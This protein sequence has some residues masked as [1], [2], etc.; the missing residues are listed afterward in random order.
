MKGISKRRT[1]LTDQQLALLTL[2]NS[3][4][5]EGE[6]QTRLGDLIP[7]AV[8]WAKQEG[9][10][11]CLTPVNKAKW[12]W[13]KCFTEEEWKGVDRRCGEAL[14]TLTDLPRRHCEQVK[15]RTQQWFEEAQT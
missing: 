1:V 6:R 8:E 2:L 12:D 10:D 9:R 11:T 13:N 14:V 7:A 4:I 5:T 3:E 15:V